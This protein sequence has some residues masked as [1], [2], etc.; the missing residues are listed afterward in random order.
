MTQNSTQNA[1][2]QDSI[3]KD[4]RAIRDLVAT[5]MAASRA[6]DTA[7]VLSLMA[8]DVV[9]QVPG[10]EPF[11][12]VAFA[13]MSESMKGV[14]MEGSSDIRELRVL[15]DWAYLRNHIAITVT[16]PGGKPVKRVGTTLTILHKQTNGQWLLAR[17]ANLLTEVKD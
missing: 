12:K 9:F 8:D 5:W 7:K 6:G 4:E 11:G 1:M 17:D 15:G 10:R 16:P 13:A 14:R 2:T 3:A